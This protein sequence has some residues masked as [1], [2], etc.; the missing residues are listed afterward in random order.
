MAHSEGGERGNPGNK[1]GGCPHAGDD[2]RVSPCEHWGVGPTPEDNFEPFFRT[3]HLPE[4]RAP[5][6]VAP[7]PRDDGAE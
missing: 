5:A 6:G 4:R 1:V 2:R 7:P 3:E